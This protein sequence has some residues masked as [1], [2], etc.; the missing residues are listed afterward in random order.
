[1]NT[2]KI[3]NVLQKYLEEN[4]FDAVV[5]CDS[6]FNYYNSSSTIT[7]ALIVAKDSAEWIKEFAISRGLK[8]DCGDFFLPFFHELGHHETMFL[9]EDEEEDYSN[10]I[11][12]NLSSTKKDY[13]IYFNLPD[14]VMATDWAIDYINNNKDK[15]QILA[16]ELQPLVEEFYRS[17]K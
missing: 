15:L 1:M 4:G 10:S 6:D 3:T 13:F 17:Y 5:E 8:Y 12:K 14:E 7:Y 2:D 16:N 11:K 9:L